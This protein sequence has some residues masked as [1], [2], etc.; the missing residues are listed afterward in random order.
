MKN[1]GSFFT[2]T[3]LLLLGVNINIMS[4]DRCAVL[5]KDIS[6]RYVGECRNGLAHGVGEAWGV[7]HYAGA[8][9]KGL[10]H[11]KGTYTYAD[12]SVYVGA[13]SKGQRHGNGKYTFKYMG[14][15]SI[16][17][18][19]WTRDI[20]KGQQ[21]SSKGYSIIS[22]RAMERYR[23]YRYTDGEE[24][25]VHLKP[26]TSGTLEVSN[27]QITGSSGYESEF[28]NSHMEFRNCQFPFRLRVSFLKWS[29]LKTVR[30]DTYI[31]LE[32]TE[33]GVWIVEIGA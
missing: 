23:V 17:E 9:K 5:M 22:S 11:G 1:P 18:G 27:L 2:I 19:M 21:K 28:L 16:Q 6:E 13:W 7:D 14:T 25:R 24:I 20:Y 26:I 10:P 31:E 30:V 29:K 3:A 8:F 12:S 15:D 4:Q 33:P 32:I